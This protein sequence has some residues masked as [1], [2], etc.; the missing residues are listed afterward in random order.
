MAKSIRWVIGIGLLLAVLAGAVAL[1]HHNFTEP[2][3][4]LNDFM[5]R[6]EG[7][8]SYW[9]DGLNPYGEQ[10]SLNIQ[11]RIYGRPATDAE[12]PGYFA[13]P[14]YTL[15]LIWPLMQTTYAWASA[16]WMVLLEACL[17]GALFA[18]FDL[19]GWKPKPWLLGVLLLW[20]L[21]FYYP[22]RGLILGQPG[23]LVY[24][25]EVLSLWA[26]FRRQDEVAGV[27]LALSTLKPQMGF[28]I[29]P[30]LLLWGL[31]VRRWRFVGAFGVV[32]GGLVLASFLLL[33]S[34][35][36]DWLAQVSIYSSYTALGSPVWIIT[37][38]YLGLGSAG[39]WAVNLL[40]Y[41][42]MLWT[43]YGVLVQGRSE[44]FL[45]AAVLTLTV[46]HLVAPRTA[47]PHYAVFILPLM[48]YLAEINR[49]GQRRGGLWSG[50]ILA[51]LLILPWLHFLLTVEGEFEHP[52][53][54][55]PLPFGML[56]LL[57]VTRGLW[58][59]RAA[60]ASPGEAT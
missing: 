52:T 42:V 28:L 9:V 40:F 21:L 7:G 47:T 36:S 44:R 45:W 25:L 43:W 51:G 49:R 1:T 57:W 60:T 29:V 38:Y 23:L 35:F 54:Y 4:G 18:Q 50:L 39:E 12:D 10:A 33:P 55:L 2:F 14:F 41:G 59:R 58:W 22:A 5:S 32:F 46:T 24:F 19:F 15:F 56:I 6:W 13:Y 16:I 3:P 30:F 37:Q 34:W 8:R 11:Q 48:F 31:R 27:A 53:V 26:L 20:T 17:I